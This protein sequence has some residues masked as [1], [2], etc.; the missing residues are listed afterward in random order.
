[1]VFIKAYHMVIKKALKMIMTNHM[2]TQS[3]AINKARSLINVEI[4]ERNFTKLR[5]VT[6]Y[7]TQSLAFH[8][9]SHLGVQ[10]CAQVMG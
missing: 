9:W 5:L 4:H 10:H 8:Y 3:R 2:R 1:M 6:F 7:M